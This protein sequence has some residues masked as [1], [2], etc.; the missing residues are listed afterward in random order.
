MN[1]VVQLF[2]VEATISAMQDAIRRAD[3]GSIYVGSN[4][5]Y[6]A[7]IELGFHG[8]DRLGRFYNQ[9][10]QPWLLPAFLGVAPTIPPMIIATFMVGG[11]AMDGLRQGADE[12][13]DLARLLVPKD[14]W[15]LHDSI[16][17][18]DA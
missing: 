13:A 12:L 4:S 17:V 7:R 8:Y 10:P 15:A 11:T 5:P 6:A 2:G 14:T 9:G 18:G 16:E 1:V 3:G